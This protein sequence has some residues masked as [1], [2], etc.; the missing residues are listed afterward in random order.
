MRRNGTWQIVAAKAFRYY[1]DPAI[2]KADAKKLSSFSGTYELAPGQVRIV[3]TENAKLY[4]ERNGKR[5]ELWPEISEVFF[6][7]GV[8]G[9]ILFRSDEQGKIDALVDRRNN[10]DIVWRKMK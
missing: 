1:E 2:G 4:L 7:K 9:R 5:E 6:R 8:E 3:M 10:E